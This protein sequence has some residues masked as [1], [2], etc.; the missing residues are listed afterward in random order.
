MTHRKPFCFSPTVPISNVTL[1]DNN[2]DLVEFNS[3]AR[4]SCSSSG[5]SPSFLW[6]NG[7][8]EVTASDRVQLTDGGSTLIIVSVT[9]YDQGLFMCH[10]ISLTEPEPV[11]Q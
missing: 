10:V 11:I 6:L 8:S 7:S 9:R 1:T 2:T 4:L 5:S 3:S